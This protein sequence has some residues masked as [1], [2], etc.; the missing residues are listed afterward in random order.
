MDKKKKENRIKKL[1]QEIDRLRFLYHVEDDPSVTDD[2]FDSL[3]KELKILLE[4]YPEFIDLDAPENR[5]GG[6]PLDKF[7]KVKH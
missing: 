6:K 4:K 3:N 1:R 2:I 5:V 7:K